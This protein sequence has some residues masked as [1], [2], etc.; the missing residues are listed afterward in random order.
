MAWLLLPLLATALVTDLWQRRI[1]NTLVLL[2]IVV[3]LGGQ[4]LT[5]GLAGLGSGGLG[6]LI[7]FVLFLPFYALGGMAAGD[8]KLM[9][10]VGAFLT[11]TL[12][13][14]AALA[15]LIAGLLCALV[16]IAVQGQAWQLAARYWLMLRTRSYLA[17]QAGE[18]AA[19]PFP[20]ALAICLGTA[21]SG[22]WHWAG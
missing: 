19:K 17:P 20:Y 9:A 5:T 21:A 8:V 7:G 13:L 22:I 3:A 15:S 2:G 12:A 1:P 10:M 11:P 14:Q 18:V 16:L 4:Y 6:M